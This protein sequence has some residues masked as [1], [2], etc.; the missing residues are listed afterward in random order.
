MAFVPKSLLLPF[1]Y[2]YLFNALRVFILPVI[3]IRFL[4][5]PVGFHFL[6]VHS[7]LVPLSYGTRSP[8]PPFLSHTTYKHSNGTSTDWISPEG[9]IV[10]VNVTLLD[11][12]I[13]HWVFGPW[14][15]PYLC[16]PF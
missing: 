5:K 4:S 1:L 13:V 14:G 12:F 10:L 3:R 8:F 9:V 16:T 7:F 2:L 6:T 15:F 11:Y